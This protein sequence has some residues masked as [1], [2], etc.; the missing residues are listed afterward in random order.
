[1][2][3]NFQNKLD[4]RIKAGDRIA[5]ISLLTNICYVDKNFSTGEF[6]EALNYVKER[7]SGIFAPS[8]D[9]DPPLYGPRVK[10]GEQLTNKDFTDAVAHLNYNFCQERVDDIK[11]LG[12]HLFPPK[13]PDSQMQW[14]QDNKKKPPRNKPLSPAE[15]AKGAV[16]VIVVGT[17]VYLLTKM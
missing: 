15:V 2:D 6:D 12:K 10:N 7:Y 8:L 9:A 17:L 11:K 5:L 4:E 1:M 13:A 16:A 14:Q 3:S